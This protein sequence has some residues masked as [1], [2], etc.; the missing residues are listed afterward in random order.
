M[1]KDNL[2]PYLVPY[3]V[4][5]TYAVKIGKI[6]QNGKENENELK[7]YIFGR[8]MGYENHFQS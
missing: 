8:K 7:I 5:R 3:M 4:V 1:L 6:Y 2:A